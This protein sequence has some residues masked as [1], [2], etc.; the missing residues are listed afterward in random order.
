MTD[1]DNKA[2]G[3]EINNRFGGH[4]SAKSMYD[5]FCEFYDGHGD[6]VKDKGSQSQ[7]EFNV[8]VGLLNK[9][10]SNLTISNYHK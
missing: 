4:T 6:L 5:T 8:F 10:L 3:A 9:S 1:H 7:T 2:L